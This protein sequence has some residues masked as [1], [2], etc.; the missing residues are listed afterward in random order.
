ME[1]AGRCKV[2][3]EGCVDGGHGALRDDI[4]DD[5]NDAD[6]ADSEQR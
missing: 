3:G 1:A 6:G 4:A 5:G 2:T